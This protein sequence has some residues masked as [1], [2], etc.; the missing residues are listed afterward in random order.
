MMKSEEKK[1]KNSHLNFFIGINKLCFKVLI[2]Q[3]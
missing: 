1:K 3:N 2:S